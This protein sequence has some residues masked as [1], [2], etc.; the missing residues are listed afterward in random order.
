MSWQQIALSV[1]GTFGHLHPALQ[2]AKVAKDRSF[3]I[4]I[5]LKDSVYLKGRDCEIISLD[6]A[7]AFLKLLKSCW[8]A[9]IVLQKKNPQV[10]ITFGS[11]HSFPATL[12]A[13]FLGKPIWV[14]EPNA[15]MG[16]ANKFFSFFAHKILCYDESLLQQFPHRGILIRPDLDYGDK[17]KILHSFQFGIDLPVLLI[18]GGSSGSTFINDWVRK[19]VDRLKA[20]QIIHLV[21]PKNDPKIFKTLYDDRGIRAFVEQFIPHV[22]EAMQI[23][24]VAITRAGASTLFE[25]HH[26]GVPSLIIPFEGAYEH[27]K[28]NALKFLCKGGI[29]VVYSE[30]EEEKLFL[31]LMGLQGL[32]KD[33]ISENKGKKWSDIISSV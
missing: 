33:Q 5:G 26:Y 18:T 20:F 31:G 10:V 4:G 3:L 1:G 22:T 8:Q 27:Q 24:D 28:Q 14:F 11:F 21:G 29:G 23:A 32:K 15:E 19:N 6:G 12:V 25:L 2:A 17:K 13:L 16:K 9:F 7:R 30:K